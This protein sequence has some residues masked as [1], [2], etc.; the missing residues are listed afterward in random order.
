MKFQKLHHS[1]GAKVLEFDPLGDPST[2]DLQELRAA[3]AQHQLLLFP[4]DRHISPE[5]QA[6]INNEWFGPRLDISGQPL[7]TVIGLLTAKGG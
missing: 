5:K 4:L 1:F 7:S 6:E 2:N 3:M